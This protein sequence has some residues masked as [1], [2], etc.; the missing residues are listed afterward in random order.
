MIFCGIG[1]ARK[2]DKVSCPQ[3]GHD[4]QPLS[5]K[6]IRTTWIMGSRWRFT[7]INAPAAARCSVL[8]PTRWW[9]DHASHCGNAP[10]KESQAAASGDPALVNFWRCRLNL[11]YGAD[12]PVLVSVAQDKANRTLK[13]RHA[14][15]YCLWRGAYFS[16][17]FDVG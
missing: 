15:A 5:Q 3:Q 10:G 16:A 11:W 2:G 8:Y 4:V 1:V 17:S 12:I 9:V 6:I 13:A 7:V 14:S